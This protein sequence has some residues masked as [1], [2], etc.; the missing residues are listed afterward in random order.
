MVTRP[1]LVV[2]IDPSLTSTGIA[3]AYPHQATA[4]TDTITT[5]GARADSLTVRHTR[6][7]QIATTVLDH[8]RGATLAV[9]EGP[10]YGS[11]GAGTWDR[12]GLWWLIVDALLSN[13]IPLA[14]APP[15]C[16]SRYAT[17]R[18]NAGKDEVMLAVARRYPDVDLENNNEAD[19]LVFAAAGAHRLGQPLV[20]VPE[21]HA[22]ALDGITWPDLEGTAA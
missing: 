17:G 8:T 10:S 13:G 2:G 9:I 4:V 18:G 14:V 6:L 12:G 20:D 21:S 16:R 5:K 1:T 22:A 7:T 19:A 3:H 15:T 11:V